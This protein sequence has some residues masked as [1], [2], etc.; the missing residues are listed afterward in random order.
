MFDEDTEESIVSRLQRSDARATSLASTGK[1]ASFGRMNDVALLEHSTEWRF[2]RK[3]LPPL[4]VV[5]SKIPRL[6]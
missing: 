5:A 6:R 1:R 3:K 2:V 4:A